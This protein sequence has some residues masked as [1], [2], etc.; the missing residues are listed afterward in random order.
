MSRRYAQEGDCKGKDVI[1]VDDLVQTGGTLYECGQALRGYGARSISAY[2][3][4]A[5]F[6]GEAWKRFC[7][8]ASMRIFARHALNF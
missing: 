4:H 2:V 3:T 8:G 7:K 6:P 1:I 5:V